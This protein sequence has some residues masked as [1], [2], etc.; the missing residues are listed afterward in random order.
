MELMRVLGDLDVSGKR[1]FVR[2]DLDVPVVTT[3]D[4]RPTTNAEQVTRLTNLRPTVDWLFDHGASK[5]IIAGH[6]DRPQKPDPAFSTEQIK[7]RLEAILSRSVIF[8]GNFDREILED[9]VLLEN[10]RFWPG[11]TKNDPEFAKQLASLADVYVNEAFGNSHRNHA[12]MVA[13]PS[14]LPHAAGVHLEE[15]VKTLSGLLLAPKRLFVAIVGGAKIETKEPLIEHLAKIA[16][17]VLV[18]GELVRELT[19]NGLQQ[20]TDNSKVMVA[21][22]TADTKDIDEVSIEKF[23]AII[24]GART[25]VWNGPMGVFEEGF[26]AGTLAVAEAILASRAYTVVGGGETTQFLA[27]K[28]LLSH[29]SF[30]SSGGG[31]MLAFLAGKTLPGL[32]ALE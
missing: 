30:V 7:E 10:L 28:N 29:F 23:K 8:T 21:T 26:E 22:L 17:Y 32:A 24:S 15:E 31:A 16:D 20:L 19:V 11:E 5:I 13:L 6:I 1:V 2:A 14:L 9:L 27:A 25:I 3:N 4:K 18:G 12:S